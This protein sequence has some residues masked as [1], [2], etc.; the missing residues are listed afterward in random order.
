MERREEKRKDWVG[1]EG[2]RERERESST[3][4]DVVDCAVTVVD[5]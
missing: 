4:H 5:G 3:S 1:V 2:K